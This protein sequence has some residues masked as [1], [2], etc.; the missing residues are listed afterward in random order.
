MINNIIVLVMIS[1]ISNITCITMYY[2]MVCEYIYIYI[3]IIIIIIISSVIIIV[4][5]VYV[6]LE[7]M[8]YHY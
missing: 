6:L 5:I 8:Y 3:Y 7:C 2:Y 1:M 4:V